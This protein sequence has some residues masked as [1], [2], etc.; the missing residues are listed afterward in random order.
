MLNHPDEPPSWEYKPEPGEED[1][2]ATY[3]K[4]PTE[5]FKDLHDRLQSMTHHLAQMQ[6]QGR[7][8]W[9]MVDNVMKKQ[10]EVLRKQEEMIK[11]VKESMAGGRSDSGRNHE[12]EQIKTQLYVFRFSTLRSPLRFI[13]VLG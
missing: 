9:E 4:T 6:Y 11:H 2:D 7:M 13:S 3:Y 8:T 12:F 5:Q 1:H 10:E